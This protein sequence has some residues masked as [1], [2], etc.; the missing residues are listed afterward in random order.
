MY[1]EQYSGRSLNQDNLQNVTNIIRNHIL[2][3]YFYMY[4]YIIR[5]KENYTYYVNVGMPGIYMICN[6]ISY[7]T[8]YS[9]HIVFVFKI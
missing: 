5:I 9:F 1:F 6:F 7:K 3:T 8:M 4:E 2:K